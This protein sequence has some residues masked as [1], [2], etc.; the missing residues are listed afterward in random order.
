MKKSRIASLLAFALACRARSPVQGSKL[1][2][3]EPSAPYRP[4]LDRIRKDDEKRRRK[5]AARRP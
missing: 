1:N 3:M 2:L 4:D 5:A